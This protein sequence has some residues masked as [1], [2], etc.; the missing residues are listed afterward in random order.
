MYTGYD[1][2]YNIKI[3]A[4]NCI[5]K[6]DLLILYFLVFECSCKPVQLYYNMNFGSVY[7]RLSNTSLV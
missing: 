3:W 4:I 5:Y 6:V 2:I 7:T 1:I